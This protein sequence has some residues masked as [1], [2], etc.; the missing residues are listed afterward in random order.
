MLKEERLQF[1]LAELERERKVVLED[2]SRSLMV[3]EDTVRR[4]I[5]TLSDRGLLRMVR[6][7]A[8]PHAPGP[9]H[10]RDRIHIAESD[11]KIIATKAIDFLHDGQVVIFDSGT[12]TLAVAGLVPREMKLTVITNSFPIANVF[13][14]HPNVDVLFAGGR[15]FKESFITNGHETLRFFNN[16]RADLCFL[17]ICSIHLEIGVTGHYYEECELKRSMVSAAEQVVAL[18]TL[19]KIG[20][21]EYYHICP[22][23]ALHT[24]ITPEKDDAKLSK[25]RGAGIRVR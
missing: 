10:F 22:A 15:L 4:D 9:H 13:E 1:I 11:K 21:A 23:A 6:G 14:E 19:E 18:S 12:S 20:T 17:G 3:S 7:G 25:F 24:I 8:V 16:V 2:L 5:R